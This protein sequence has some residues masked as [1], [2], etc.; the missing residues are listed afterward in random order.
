MIRKEEKKKSVFDIY[1]EQKDKL[2]QD[3]DTLEND[4][5]NLVLK[6]QKFLTGI[7]KAEPINEKTAVNKKII[8]LSRSLIKNTNLKFK[9]ANIKSKFATYQRQWEK[10]LI[11][12][13]EGKFERGSLVMQPVKFESDANDIP[14]QRLYKE[15]VTAKIEAKQKV[16]NLTFT[17]FKSYLTSTADKLKE[18]LKG[19]EFEFKVVK[20]DN[21]VKLVATPLVATPLAATQL[22][23]KPTTTRS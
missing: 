2:T 7:E 14:L 23:A 3:I 8:Q 9:F 1:L 6:Y 5:K 21:K 10:Y 19:K 4:V 17:A 20:D 22:T 12:I 13:D 16:G 11:L 15:Y 18:Q